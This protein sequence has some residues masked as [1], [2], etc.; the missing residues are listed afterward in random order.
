MRRKLNGEH[1]NPYFK[2]GMTPYNAGKYG[3]RRQNGTL[4]AGNS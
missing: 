3:T 1:G 2:T 4:D